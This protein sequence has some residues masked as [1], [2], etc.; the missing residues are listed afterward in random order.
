MRVSVR[1][2]KS[3]YG[4]TGG[5]IADSVWVC[6]R[7]CLCASLSLSL[8]LSRARSLSLSLPLHPPLSLSVN[9]LA[10]DLFDASHVLIKL[11]R[12]QGLV[13][14]QTACPWRDWRQTRTVSVAATNTDGQSR[15][16]ALLQPST[17]VPAMLS[18]VVAAAASPCL[19]PCCLAPSAARI[20]TSFWLAEVGMAR[21]PVISLQ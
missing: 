17:C 7:V 16:D 11:S 18:T 8:S 10:L 9:L 12:T 2:I 6:V 3:T 5:G 4:R 15:R 20:V 1:R 19:R 21:M 14:L 13:L